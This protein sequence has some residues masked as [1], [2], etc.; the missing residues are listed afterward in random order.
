[1]PCADAA[2]SFPPMVSMS[3]RT[4]ADANALLRAPAGGGTDRFRRAVGNLDG[5]ERRGD[6]D[7]G[8]HHH[9][10]QGGTRALARAHAGNRAAGCLRSVARLQQGRRHDRRRAVRAGTGGAARILRD[11]ARGQSYRQRRT[12]FGRTGRVAAAAGAAC[13]EQRRARAGQTR[14]QE[15]RASAVAV[16]TPLC[17][18]KST[19]GA[20]YNTLP[21]L[22]M[23]LGSSV[24]LSVRIR[25]YATGSFT[26]GRRSRFITP[27]PCSAEIE[28]PCLATTPK[29]AALTSP[30]CERNSALSAP[31]GWAT[32]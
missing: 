27:M 23:P 18:G 25:S 15:G 22:R 20:V 30:Q 4:K 11:F 31:T 8:H 16:L 5:A 21:G 2:A 9:R 3:G 28:P 1:M 14:E 10:G 24:R 6:G 17:A 12:E 19:T 29:T 32:L 7:G 26:L 13:R